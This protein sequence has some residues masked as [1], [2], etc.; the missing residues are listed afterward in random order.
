[1]HIQTYKTEIFKENQNLFDFL[2]H[3]LP[4]KIQ[5]NTIIVVTSKIVALSEGRTRTIQSPEDKEAIIRSESDW[6]MRTKYTWLTIKNNM[7][8]ASAGVDESNADGKIILLPQDSFH[9]AELIRNQLQK[10]YHVQNLGVLITD[11]RLLPLRNGTV[12]VALGYT[13]F[14]G[15]RDY[16]GT[17]DMFGRVLKLSRVDVADSLAT[18]AVLQMGEGDECRPLALITEA[19]VDFIDTVDQQELD[20]DIRE[21][22]YQPLFENMKNIPEQVFKKLKK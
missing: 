16:R 15:L 7:I 19:Y 14:V 10:H 12:G 20:I 3:W 21:D 5:E 17:K 2:I 22:L 1:M 18:A 8:M 6:M 11:S 9:S 4:E 13:G